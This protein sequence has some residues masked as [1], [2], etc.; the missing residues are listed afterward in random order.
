MQLPEPLL[1]RALRDWPVA[2]LALQD[3]EQRPRVLPIVFVHVSGTFWTPVDGKPKA[4][5]EP[6]RVRHVQANPWVE[7]LLDDYAH[8]WAR[9]WWVR[10][11]GIARVVRPPDPA[12]DPDVAPVVEALRSK[13]P[14]YART[15][16][17]LDPPTLIAIR[18]GRVRSWC[19]G[20]DAARALEQAPA[21]G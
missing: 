8:D 21:G 1:D 5:G 4:A 9:L 7:L 15:P 2:R 18:P 6:A 12:S 13:Y 19:A 17:L 20:P 11:D 10:V 3:G 14:Q 16:V